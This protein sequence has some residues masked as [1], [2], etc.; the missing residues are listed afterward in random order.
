MLIWRG[1]WA[2]AER[3][4]VEMERELERAAPA[5]FQECAARLGELRRRQGR[6]DEAETF[7]GRAGGHRLALT[8][9]AAI[10]LERGS[11]ERALDLV[12]RLFR[13]LRE[14]DRLVRVPG[15]LVQARAADAL[16]LDEVA[17]SAVASLRS[18]AAVAA[19]PGLEAT[20]RF[21]EGFARRRAG[22]PTACAA[23]EDAA[24]LFASAGAPW[25]AACA[26][27]EAARLALA[28]G[29]CE[30]ARS[31]AAAALAVLRELGA[32][33]DA[34]RA[35]E[36]LEAAC[37]PG[38]DEAPSAPKNDAPPLS[39]RQREVLALVAQGLSNREIGQRLFV[40]ELTVKRHVADILTRL[41]VPTRAAAAA[42]AMQRGWL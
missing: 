13:R 9:R 12:E 42:L 39:A 32:E 22:P 27:V 18:L 16:G 36:L 40:S 11:P 29:R 21:A 10:A 26:Q 19:S 17:D 23:F 28:L 15:W 31:E 20:A 4:L 33:T 2:E 30:T 14:E 24:D 6:F 38:P 7:Y 5:V 25:E 41:E 35:A 1:R 37:E 8:G 3:E 34:A